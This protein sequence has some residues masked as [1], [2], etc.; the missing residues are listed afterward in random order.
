MNKLVFQEGEPIS[1]DDIEETK[2][3]RETKKFWEEKREIG[4]K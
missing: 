2:S 3:Q 4:E 1:V